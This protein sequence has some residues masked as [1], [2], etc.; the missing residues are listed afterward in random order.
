MRRM[1]AVLFI[2]VATIGRPVKSQEIISISSVQVEIWP[3][4]DRP[5]VL[6]IYHVLLTDD[7]QL[8]ALVTIKIPTKAELTAVAVEDPTLG[9]ILADYS[10][11]EESNWTKLTIIAT[12]PILQLE[13]YDSILKTGNMR[14]I[15]FEWMSDVP[16]DAF[17][18]A[19]QNPIS[20]TDIKL[21]P[22]SIAIQSGQYNLLYNIIEAV[23]LR[24]GEKFTFTASY[25][26]GDD[27]L[28]V[29]S[30]PVEPL[31]PL[32]ETAGQINWNSVLPWIMGIV[33]LI[34]IIL[35][36]LVFFGFKGRFKISDRKRSG[37]PKSDK[38][39]QEKSDNSVANYCSECGQ[40]AQPGDQ[41]CRSCG[42]QLTRG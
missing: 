36:L 6:V 16:V 24:A 18:V 2:I 3:E 14:Q 19:F 29:A 12:T 40:R 38:K 7:T 1:I 35:G 30:L 4:F 9:L 10:L 25:E 33:G 27:V 39:R 5:E 21:N 28:S 31:V 15:I 26:K 23:S 17:S 13:Y 42:N 20:A 22:S 34:F 32:D 41:F 37:Y 11:L 8:P